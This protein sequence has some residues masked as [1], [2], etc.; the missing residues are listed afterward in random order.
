MWFVSDVFIKNNFIFM[1]EIVLICTVRTVL[2][3]FVSVFL[4]NTETYNEFMFLQL[5]KGL[6]T[7]NIKTNLVLIGLIKLI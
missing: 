5:T 6:N 7:A 4:M 2:A 1:K 3:D